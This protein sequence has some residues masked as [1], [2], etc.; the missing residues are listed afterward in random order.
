[1]FIN[2]IEDNSYLVCLLE[3]EYFI[4]VI[5]E[6]WEFEN[7][8]FL[9]AICLLLREFLKFSNYFAMNI[10]KFNFLNVIINYLT[11]P[12]G[13]IINLDTAEDTIKIINHI[14]K[15]CSITDLSKD[16]IIKIFGIISDNYETFENTKVFMNIC[17]IL[18]YITSQKQDDL[19]NLIIS[20]EKFLEKI[21][22]FPIDITKPRDTL[23]IDIIAN[24]MMGEDNII[25]VYSLL[26]LN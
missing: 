12:N 8:Y 14:V 22:N 6:D 5:E 1:M 25:E 4:K 11:I 7:Q 26:I 2:A 18:Y 16:Q 9:E 17:Y 3:D 23:F 24:L 20:K 10:S 19:L 15:S 21:L 13:K